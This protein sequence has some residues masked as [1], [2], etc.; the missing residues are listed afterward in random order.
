MPRW[1]FGVLVQT[2]DMARAMRKDF[3]RSQSQSTE[4]VDLAEAEPRLHFN[5]DSWLFPS[6]EG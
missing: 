2:R 4:D 1:E 3:S 5:S 6:S